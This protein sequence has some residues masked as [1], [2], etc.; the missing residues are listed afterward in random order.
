[1]ITY[2]DEKGENRVILEKLDA[3]HLRELLRDLMGM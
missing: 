2:M 1:M 3:E